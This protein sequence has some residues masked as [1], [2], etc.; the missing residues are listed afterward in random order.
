MVAGVDDG[1]IIEPDAT[2]AP[3]KA[4]VTRLKIVFFIV[5]LP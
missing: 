2:T 4:D 1:I 5:I 3:I